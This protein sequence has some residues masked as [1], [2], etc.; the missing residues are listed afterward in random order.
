MWVFALAFKELGDGLAAGQTV[1]ECWVDAA[2]GD[3]RDHA[4]GTADEEGALGADFRNGELDSLQ[5]SPGFFE[6]PKSAQNHGSHKSLPMWVKHG[7]CGYFFGGDG[8]VLIYD[9]P[10]SS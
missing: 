7:A 5:R 8:L 6:W 4:G 1:L 2:G 3:G 10:L 9:E